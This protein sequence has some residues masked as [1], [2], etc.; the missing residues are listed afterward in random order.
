[1]AH[2]MTARDDLQKKLAG[3]GFALEEKWTRTIK[4]MALNRV[5]GSLPL[6]LE[7]GSMPP[8]TTYIEFRELLGALAALI[9]K[10][11]LF[12]CRTYD[13]DDPL[14]SF[15]ELDQ[16]IRRV[17][18]EEQGEPPMKAPFTVL[19]PGVCRTTLT[20]EHFERP[21]GYLLGIETK[22]D[23]TKL[24]PYVADGNKFKLMPTSMELAAVFGLELQRVPVPPIELPGGAHYFRLAPASN[25]RRWDQI[26][27]DKA[28]SLVWNNREFDLSD[29]AFTLWMPLR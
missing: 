15:K 29:A 5:C 22:T 26:K 12:Q 9:E 17:I 13:H 24:A 20:A 19:R 7:E 8:V 21:A 6:L 25:Q 16:K 27:N 18:V 14:P 23:I 3:G 4:L 11:D 1:M 2:V 28:I 10:E